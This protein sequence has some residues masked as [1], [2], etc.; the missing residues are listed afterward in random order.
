VRDERGFKFL[1]VAAILSTADRTDGNAQAVHALSGAPLNPLENGAP[2]LT[3]R[4]A[5]W[6]QGL[7]QR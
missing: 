1:V 7:A 3:N 6:Q 2:F 4:R 5:V